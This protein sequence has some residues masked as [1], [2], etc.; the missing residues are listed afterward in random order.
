MT[1]HRGS[2]GDSTVPPGF[3]P[4]QMRYYLHPFHGDLRWWRYGPTIVGV[5]GHRRRFRRS[6]AGSLTVGLLAGPT[7]LGYRTS[8]W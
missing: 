7:D 1:V 6:L 2:Y 3:H 5:G 8:H 4:A